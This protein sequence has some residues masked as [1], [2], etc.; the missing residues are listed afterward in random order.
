V[1]I[2]TGRC[3]LYVHPDRKVQAVCSTRPE[4]GTHLPVYTFSYPIYFGPAVGKDTSA[5]IFIREPRFTLSVPFHQRSITAFFSSSTDVMHTWNLA[6]SLY[7][8][9]LRVSNARIPQHES[10]SRCSNLKVCA[11]LCSQCANTC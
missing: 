2:Q 7:K 4:V 9:P 10:L 1:I 8:I 11:S 3:R 6:A 5:M